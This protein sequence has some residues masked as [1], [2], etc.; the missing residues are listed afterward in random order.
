MSH[1][2]ILPILLAAALLAA[3]SVPVAPAAAPTA[4]PPTSLPAPAATPITPSASATPTIAPLP[5]PADSTV[6]AEGIGDSYFPLMGNSGYDV[7]HYTLDLTVDVATDQIQASEQIDAIATQDLTRFDLDFAGMALSDLTLD[8]QPANYERQSGELIITPPNEIAS[9]DL[10]TVNLTYHGEPGDGVPRDQV[11]YSVGWNYFGDGVVVAGE[12]SGAQGWYAVNGHPL[13]KATYSITVT[14]PWPY[15]AVSNGELTSTTDNG[16]TRTFAWEMRYPMAS[17]LATVGISQFN[18]VKSRSA[19]GIALRSFFPPDLPAETR[20][21]FDRIG[22][23]LDYYTSVFGPYPFDEAGVVVYP[24]EF[25]FSLETQTLITFGTSFNDEYVVAHELAHQWFGDSV[26][27]SRW[28]DIWLNE[29]FA[30]YASN[31]WLED[32]RALPPPTTRYAACTATW[33][34]STTARR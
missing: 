28:Q 27:L 19:G 26:S 14:V 34:A 21:H 20:A 30:T 3:C 9:G 7:Q 17:Y 13:D 1:R 2:R 29:G 25:N 6:G 32:W 10:F 31:L 8:G 24:R 12:P 4:I 22:D 11:T 23:M 18:E 15:T 5:T 33:P 16:S